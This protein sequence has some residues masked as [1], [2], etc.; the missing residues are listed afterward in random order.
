MIVYQKINSRKDGTGGG[1]LHLSCLMDFDTREFD[2]KL[3]TSI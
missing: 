3:L 2:F 1:G